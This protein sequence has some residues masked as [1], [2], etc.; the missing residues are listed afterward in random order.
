MNLTKFSLT[1]IKVGSL[2]TLKIYFMNT[3][4]VKEDEILKIGQKIFWQVKYNKHMFNLHSI[5]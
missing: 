1:L 5:G 2:Y 4:T 3:L